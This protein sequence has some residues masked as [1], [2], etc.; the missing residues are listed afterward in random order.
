MATNIYRFQTAVVPCI[1]LSGTGYT[2]TNVQSD[3]LF[4]VSVT[5]A[6]AAE[7][8]AFL[9]DLTTAMAQSGYTLL[10][11]NPAAPVEFPYQAYP[12]VNAT[13]VNVTTATTSGASSSAQR[14]LPTGNNAA[15]IINPTTLGFAV[16]KKSGTDTVLLVRCTMSGSLS[17]ASTTGQSVR[18]QLGY[19]TVNTTGVNTALVVTGS[20]ASG[21]LSSTTINACQWRSAMEWRISGLAAGTYYFYVGLAV[22]ATSGTASLPAGNAATGGLLFI[23]EEIR[24]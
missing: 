17:V 20:G 1:G 16:V 4:D 10:A 13:L 9:A 2:A 8:A 14:S 18:A 19:T 24:L 12:V 11:T 7:D 3:N 23:A 6:D 22:F 5:G 15:G 21:S